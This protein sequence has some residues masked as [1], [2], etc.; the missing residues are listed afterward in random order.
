MTFPITVIQLEARPVE[1]HT[2][3]FPDV[4]EDTGRQLRSISYGTPEGALSAWRDAG[5]TAQDI[6]TTDA[7][8][9]ALR[10]ILFDLEHAFA[11]HGSIGVT[12][13][14]ARRDRD[15]AQARFNH[16]ANEFDA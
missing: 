1:T 14:L 16:A 11:E 9:R 3:L 4:D 8:I 2:V 12:L 10:N 5:V 15:R 7:R 13:A 6:V